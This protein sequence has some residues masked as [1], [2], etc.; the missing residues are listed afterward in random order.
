MYIHYRISHSYRSRKNKF[1]NLFLRLKNKNLII[2]IFLPSI[3][4]FI[5]IS[6]DCD[7]IYCKVNKI[8][9]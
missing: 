6:S 4:S 3:A 2:F 5:A 7:I 9:G 1:N 8:I